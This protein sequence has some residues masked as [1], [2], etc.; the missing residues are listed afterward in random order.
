MKTTM[1]YDGG[2]P[3]CMRGV[4]HYRRLDWAGRLAWV[5]LAGPGFDPSEHGLDFAAAMDVLHVRGRDGAIRSG[6]PAFLELWSE[7][8]AYRRLASVIRALRLEGVFDTAYRR[9]ARGRFE[10]R[11]AEGV[12]RPV[13][14]S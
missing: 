9:L 2:C 3:L 1:F 10:R 11:C 14:A 7:L 4:E 6:G 8:P 13:K 12:C 5:D